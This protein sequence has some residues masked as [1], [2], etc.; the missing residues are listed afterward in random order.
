M[1]K[2]GSIYYKP[3]APIAEAADVDPDKVLQ[4][5]R[6]DVMRR[7]K[8]NLLQTA[9]SERAKKALAQA[10]TVELRPSSLVIIANHPAFRPLVEGQRKMQMTWLTKAKAPIPIITETGELIFRSA[11]PK[12]MRDGKWVHPGRQPSNY[13]EKAKTQAKEHIKEQLEKELR[14]Q[15]REALSKAGRRKR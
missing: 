13:L 14:R 7:I 3:F 15:V 4:K 9:F 10:V 12:S 2:I 8:S 11:T 1:I 5:L 6:R